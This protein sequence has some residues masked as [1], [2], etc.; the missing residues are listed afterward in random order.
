MSF[1]IHGLINDAHELPILCCE[2]NVARKE[3]YSGSQDTSI[4]VWDIE[5]LKLIRKQNGHKGWVTSMVYSPTT[6]LLFSGSVDGTILVWNEKGV[7]L[8]ALST[9]SPIFTLTS[10]DQKQLLI[11]GGKNGI[12]LFR[13]ESAEKVMQLDREHRIQSQSKNSKIL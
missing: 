12:S 6:K 5:S 10:N 1:E 9:Q 3:L 13:T 2:L 7:A 8:Q 11:S 4:R